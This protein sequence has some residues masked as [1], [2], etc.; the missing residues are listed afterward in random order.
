M[1][2][3]KEK[4]MK[5]T[6]KSCSLPIIYGGPAVASGLGA[7][8]GWAIG[9]WKS[10]AKAGFLSETPLWNSTIASYTL[11]GTLAG[12]LVGSVSGAIFGCRK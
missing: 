11:G 3:K 12:L 2:E 1:G 4:V 9:R 8:A 5:M 6:K 10:A 7:F